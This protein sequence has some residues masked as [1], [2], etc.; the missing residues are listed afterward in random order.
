VRRCSEAIWVVRH[1]LPSAASYPRTLLREV[2]LGRVQVPRNRR[3]SGRLEESTPKN[4]RG[5]SSA[6]SPRET[7]EF[8]SNGTPVGVTWRQ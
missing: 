7:P 4:T 6:C 2:I 1:S 3:C 8:G 5:W